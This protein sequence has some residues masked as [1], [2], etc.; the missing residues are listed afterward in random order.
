MRRFSS[1]LI[2][3]LL[4]GTP[5]FSN[6][7]EGDPSKDS[8]LQRLIEKAQSHDV[9]KV[10]ELSKAPNDSIKIPHSPPRRGVA[11]VLTI[12]V[13]P[14]GGHRLY[15]GTEPHVPVLYTVTLGG[16]LG[17]LPL[18][19]LIQLIVSDDMDRFLDNRR[20]FMWSRKE[21]NEDGGEE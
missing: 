5:S 10:K 12:L 2:I 15:L 16:G 3:F 20:V 4:L 19:D 21:G 8:L 18:I 11:I 17:L 14:L 9:L 6:E 1:I 13:G 7:P